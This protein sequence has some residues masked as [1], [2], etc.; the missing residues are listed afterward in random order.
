MI[1]PGVSLNPTDLEDL[2]TL[3]GFKNILIRDKERGKNTE[4]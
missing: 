2:K 1:N 4:D 3:Y